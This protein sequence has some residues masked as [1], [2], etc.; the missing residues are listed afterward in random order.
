MRPRRRMSC[1]D[2]TDPDQLLRL[3]AVGD[4]EA[5]EVLYRELARPAYGVIRRVL[6]DPAQSEEVTQEVMLEVWRTAA[7]FDPAR[8][9]AAT[10]GLTIAHRRGGG[11]GGEGGAG[12]GTGD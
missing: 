5:F 12:A 9:S 6:C 1:M 2:Q 7:R 4:Q 3:V 11:P 8:S 10:W